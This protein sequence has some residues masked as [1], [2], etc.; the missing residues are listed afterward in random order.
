MECMNKKQ[1]ITL[2]KTIDQMAYGL[3]LSLE[4]EL[5]SAN[6]FFLSRC[7]LK[8][9]PDNLMIYDFEWG[10]YDKDYYERIIKHISHGFS[11]RDEIK[12]SFQGNQFW[13]DMNIAPSPD[14]DEIFLFGLDITERKVNEEIIKLQQQQIFTQSQFSALGEMASGIAH[15]INNPLAIISGSCTVI[16]QSLNNDEIDRE[17]LGEMMVDIK[18]TV[19]R[20][21]KIIQ[22]LRNISR[23]PS[24][25]EFEMVFIPELF[26]D[27][28]SLCGEKFRGKGIDLRTTGLDQ[29]KTIPVELLKIQMSQVILNLLNNAYDAVLAASHDEKWIDLKFIHNQRRDE[30]EIHLTDSGDGVC[31]EIVDKIFNP[32]FTTKDIGKGTGLGLSLSKAIIKRH[33]G[34]FKL[35]SDSEHTQF[36]LKF[37][38]MQNRSTIMTNPASLNK[39]DVL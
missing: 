5:I 8:E 26:Q 30:I 18:D 39:D 37:P 34:E 10:Q 24:K 33:Q 21:S 13:M 38:R 25:D 20:I 6:S 4:G 2:G 22:G 35:N 17:F 14:S 1:N 3:V 19:K 23:D 9:L 28:V 27:V 15:E 31:N 36:I 12:M 11:W 16:N 7:K 29:L 32:F